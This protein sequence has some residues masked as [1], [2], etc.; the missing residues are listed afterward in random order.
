[1]LYLWIIAVYFLKE[2]TLSYGL[3]S[4]SRILFLE[5]Q[6]LH[7]PCHWIPHFSFTIHSHIPKCVYQKSIIFV[8]LSD[9]LRLKKNAVHQAS[10]F[11]RG[12]CA[13]LVNVAIQNDSEVMWY[14]NNSCQE[15][16]G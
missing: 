8:E 2:W 15:P 4:L 6:K 9:T 5:D 3:R 11:R 14:V 12:S 10:I 1:M 16:L 7:F 13:V